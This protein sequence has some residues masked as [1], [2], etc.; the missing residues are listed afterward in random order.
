MRWHGSGMSFS[1]AAVF[2]QRALGD[3]CEQI[4]SG[5]TPARERARE[6]YATTGYPWVKTKELLDKRIHDTEEHITE[7]ALRES[8]AK[9]LPADTVLVAMYASPTVGR[10]GVLTC[11]AACNQA[12]AA[13]MVDRARADF[14]F[15]F[16]ALLAERRRL[17]QIASGS[18]QQNINARIVREFEIPVPPLREQRSVSSV[19]GALDDKI[20]SNARLAE[21]LAD[22][23]LDEFRGRFVDLIGNEDRNGLP[24]GWKRLELADVAVLHRD[25]VRGD[26][27]LPYIG[28]DDMP[29]G[30]TVLGRWKARG[31]PDGQAARFDSGDM[32]FGKLRPYFKKVGVAPVEGRCSTEILVVRPCDE[33]YYGFVLGHLASD[34]FIEHCV[35]VSRGT[36]MPRSEWKDAATFAV[37][38]PPRAVAR[39]F[40]DL[41]LATYAKIKAL[42]LETQTVRQIR[43]ELLPK[44]VSGE[45]RVP[46]GVAGTEALVA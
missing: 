12:C 29:R 4:T 31:A 39:E 21:A 18:A 14:R 30:S 9:L 26:V 22:L 11:E 24:A 15:V 42:T 10:L 41:T 28:L 43:D 6:F 1:N 23:V 33:A 36:R 27:E 37:A 7:L 45:I 20:E 40:T 34:R 13:L 5:G 16:Y 2:P 46:V 3:L 44:L 38:V 8:A 35:A 32:L 17:Q 19:L 25:F